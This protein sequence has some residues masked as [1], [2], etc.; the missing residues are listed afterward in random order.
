MHE[1]DSLVRPR[2]TV[3]VVEDDEQIRSALQSGLA[4]AGYDVT[5]VGD[6]TDALDLIAE[7]LPALIVLDLGLP[8]LGGEALVA[9]LQ[10]RGVRPSVPILIL[11]ADPD[12]DEVVARIAAEGFLP[13]P[14]HL[15][16]LLREVARLAAA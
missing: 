2:R 9:E 3:L 13:K 8:C 15:A 11:S 7:R 16:A 10:R 14:L 4:M 5:A 6:G 1:R 12:A